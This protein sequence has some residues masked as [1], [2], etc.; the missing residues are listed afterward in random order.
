MYVELAQCVAYASDL[1][2]QSVAESVRGNQYRFV[3]TPSFIQCGGLDNT[4]ASDLPTTLVTNTALNNMLLAGL[5]Y[6]TSGHLIA[7]NDG[8]F[9]TL[10]Y[11]QEVLLALPSLSALNIDM[12][13][14]G[15]VVGLG[16]VAKRKEVTDADAN[17]T[18]K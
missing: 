16:Q 7:P 14:K 11:L 17:Q 10:N 15:F 1:S 5:F 6:L 18:T 13:N 2:A 9:P 3:I 12:N 8:N 4:T